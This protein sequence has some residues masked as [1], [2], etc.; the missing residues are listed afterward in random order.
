MEVPFTYFI[1]L[2]LFLPV[3]RRNIYK[4]TRKRTTKSEIRLQALEQIVV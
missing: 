4:I 2:S 1:D 3:P